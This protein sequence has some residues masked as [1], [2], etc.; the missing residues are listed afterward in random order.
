MYILLCQRVCYTTR[1]ISIDV[2]SEFMY[3]CM[4]V[5][6]EKKKLREGTEWSKD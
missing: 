6:Q 3:A 4:Q 5:I 2:I 1:H